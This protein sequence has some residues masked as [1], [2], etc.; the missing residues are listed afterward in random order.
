M[1]TLHVHCLR[2]VTSR[3]I[4]L[5][6]ASS[7]TS[8]EFTITRT[9]QS[10]NSLR[11]A[12]VSVHKPTN[13]NECYAGTCGCG[14]AAARGPGAA[15]SGVAAAKF[16]YSHVDGFGKKLGNFDRAEEQDGMVR[17]VFR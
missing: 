15:C 16:E 4:E 11:V 14:R 13:W 5:E 9:V 7:E 10:E 17:E 3:R 2:K 12:R 8:Q 6:N 1:I